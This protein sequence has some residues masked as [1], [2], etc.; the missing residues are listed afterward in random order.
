[1]FRTDLFDLRPKANPK[2]VVQGDKYRFTVLTER[3]IR[4]E[5][6][7]SGRFQDAPTKMVFCRDF[8]VPEFTVT[9]TEEKL[10][11]VTDKLHLCYDKKPFSF[12]GL[13]IIIKGLIKH[14][15]YKWC[16][17]IPQTTLGGKTTNLLGTCCT[18]DLADGAVPLGDGVLDRHGFVTLDDSHTMALGED[19]WY[20]P[21][22]R[23]GCIDLYFLGYLEEHKDCVRDFYRLSG[24]MPM[25]PR[26]ALG[27]WWCRYYK[28]TE[29]TYMELMEK[30]WERKVPMAV[31]VLDMDWHITKPDPKYG[32]GWTGYTWNRDFFPDPERFLRWLHDNGLRVTMN[33][34]PCDGIRGFE[35]CYGAAAKSMGVDAETEEP[36]E[37]DASD[38]KFM[39]T[40]LEDVLHPLEDQGVDFWWID[41]QQQGGVTDPRYDPLWMLNHYLYADNARKGEYPL[42]LSRYAGPGSHR[43][44]LG[45]S[46]D[47]VMTWESLDF[48]PYFT[49]VASNIGY[50]WWSHDIGGH[51]M[52]VWDDDLQIRWLQYGVFSPIMRLHSGKDLFFLKE[53]WNFPIG[54]EYI[55]EDFMRLRHALV[56]YLYTMNYRNHT[57]GQPLC[58]PMYYEY[59]HQMTNDLTFPNQYTFGSELMVCPITSPTDRRAG[60]GRVRAWIPEGT[61][62]DFFTG[63][64]YTG[65][66]TMYLYRTQEK[67]PVL[68]KAGAIVPLADDGFVNGT[69][70][71]KQLKICAFAGAD[72]SFDLYEDDEKLF[73][74]RSAVTP[75]RLAWGKKTVFA[76]LPVS[77]D[78]SILPAARRYALELTGL[79]QP[80][81][82]TVTVNG[83]PVGAA[84]RYASGRLTVEAVEAS[85]ADLLEVTVLC[86]GNL[87][88]NDWQAEFEARLVRYQIENAAK[89]EFMTALGRCRGDRLKFASMLPDLCKTDPYIHGELTEILLSAY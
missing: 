58:C 35:D 42:T 5:W 85:A 37:F 13:S 81:E 51:K 74:T 86:S 19:G 26:Y 6:D 56:P 29:K 52:G 72:G 25:L 9:E 27:N 44:P 7:E 53:P 15:L 57:E 14:K 62:F 33:L 76:K 75:L 49:N 11:I 47:T 46:G 2:A 3:M 43:Y 67:Y 55:M 84:W 28:Y 83:R 31:S 88:E 64:R 89:T 38:P 18:L 16:Y 12:G 73:A 70:L 10:E 63:R 4:M 69:P 40:Y 24:R 50:G 32:N 41:W 48:Q 59:P 8:P 36:V 80:E 1:M 39:Q 68:A 21:A 66:K 71:P 61:W 82:V 23:E 22:E 78:A 79:E 34:H 30:F 65:C 17:G 60:T 20:R 87:A 77:G 45:F 54:T